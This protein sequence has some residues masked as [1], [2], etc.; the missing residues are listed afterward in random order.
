MLFLQ[1]TRRGAIF[2][3]LV[4]LFCIGTLVLLPHAHPLANPFWL[5]NNA[6]LHKAGYN[7]LLDNTAFSSGVLLSPART[8]SLITAYIGKCYALEQAYTKK[9]QASL[10]KMFTTVCTQMELLERLVNRSGYSAMEKSRFTF[11]FHQFY[12]IAIRTSYLV[13]DISRI[14]HYMELNRLLRDPDAGLSSAPIS[15]NELQNK[16]LKSRQQYLSYFEDEDHIYALLADG[17]NITCKQ[18]DFPG[19]LDT[20]RRFTTL[21]SDREMVNAHYFSYTRLANML[22]QKLIAPMDIAPGNLLISPGEHFIPFEALTTDKAGTDFLLYHF[23]ISYT[24]SATRQFRVPGRSATGNIEFL[25]IAPEFYSSKV[26]LP[27]LFGAV[28]SLRKIEDCFTNSV[29]LSQQTASRKSFLESLGNYSVLHIYSHAGL[30]STQPFL[31]LHDDPVYINDI[32]LSKQNRLQLIF[33]AGCETAVAGS[34]NGTDYSMADR[35]VYAGVPSTVATLWQVENKAV[36]AISE[37][38]YRL[39]KLG[40]PRNR[41]LQQAKIEF[42]KQGIK[43]NQLPYYWASIILFG[44]TEPIAPA[45]AKKDM[46]SFA[47]IL[48]IVLFAFSR[49]YR[50]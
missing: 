19:Y 46:L 11:R 28:Q 4:S 37:S 49:R 18:I 48:N 26:A 8:D 3:F 22:Y 25:G 44:D 39:L 20:V 41:A 15:L 21:C 13:K 42:V 35:F 27:R 38:F 6:S 12:A 7:T 29:I 32:N 14:Y 33:L 34:E 5:G 2:T 30:H 31:S 47:A 24:Q 10:W 17:K 9:N 45:P 36:Y 23:A 50:I 16:L 40:V 43:A 1:K